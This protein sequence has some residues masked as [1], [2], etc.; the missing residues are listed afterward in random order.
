LSRLAWA[1]AT[2]FRRNSPILQTTAVA[3]GLTETQ[4][5]ELFANAATIVA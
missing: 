3:L 4:L 5:D 1:D 2:E